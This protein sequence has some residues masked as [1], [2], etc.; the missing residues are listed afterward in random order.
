MGGPDAWET[1]A[2]ELG[3]ERLVFGTRAGWFEEESVLFRLRTAR[4]SAA[5]QQLVIAGNLKRLGGVGE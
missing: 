3:A 1:V 2:G 4:L 5:D